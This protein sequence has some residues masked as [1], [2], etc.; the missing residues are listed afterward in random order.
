MPTH[1]FREK[2]ISALNDKNLQNALHKLK[3]GFAA[4]RKIATD[5]LPEFKKI[6][7]FAVQCKDHT[8]DF[9][10]DYLLQY[11]SNV[12]AS[13]G[14]VHWATNGREACNI[15][16]R[17]CQQRKARRI[18]KGKSMLT[19]EIFLNTALEKA[20]FHVTE[21]DLGEYIIQLRNEKP[22]HIVAPAIHVSK[23]QI[24]TDFYLHHTEQAVDRNLSTV[25]ALLSEARNLLRQEFLQ[26]DIGITGANFL[27]AETGAS[28]IVTNEGNG[29]LT[30]TCAK[31]HIVIAG[32]D[33]IVPTVN[34]ALNT[35]RLLCRSAT[36][37]EIT[38]YVTFSQGPRRNED[39]DGPEEYHVI[40]VDNGRSNLLGTKHQ[41]MLR[42]IRCA[43]CLN[44]CP[45]YAAV[46]GHTYSS[47]YQGPMGAVFSPHLFG[48]QYMQD[49]PKASTFCGRCESVCP[50]Q[51]PLT[52]MMR[53]FREEALQKYFTPITE[54]TGLTFWAF[55]ARNPR[56]YHQC[57]RFLSYLLR[58]FAKKKK[59]YSYLPFATGWTHFRTLAVPANKTFHQLWK[60][61]KNDKVKRNHFI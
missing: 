12:L 25:N 16:L 45:V 39:M 27:I 51:I 29:D 37:Q 54:R 41:S 18:T 13:G 1:S 52:S 60:A 42:C 4:K 15:V 56:L 26:A 38:S 44:H 9:L 59:H 2:S 11:E 8:L 49:L 19:E 35:L 48:L 30:Q 46:G 40:L 55:I 32:I 22:S 33:K 34:H 47:P 14:H 53:D 6:S 21:T 24:A 5:Q 61:Q 43:A 17:L 58:F 3:N 23:K 10:D 28:V 57:T 36:G 31:T 7:D 20:G 50:M